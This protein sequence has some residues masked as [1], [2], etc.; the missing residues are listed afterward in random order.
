MVDNPTACDTRPKPIPR[1]EKALRIILTTELELFCDL[2]GEPCIRLPASTT[3][4]RQTWSLRSSRTRFWMADLIWE[5]AVLILNDHEM[6]CILNVLM[7][8]ACLDER[9]DIELHQAMDQDP[10]EQVF[11]P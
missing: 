6:T 8:K 2:T 5:K 11:I 1:D 3:S 4:S 9:T 10:L 7:G